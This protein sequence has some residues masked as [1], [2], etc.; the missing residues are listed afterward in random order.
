MR[1]VMM[2]TSA[3]A[4]PTLAALTTFADVVAVVTQPDRPSGRGRHLSASPVKQFAEQH[5]MTVYQPE[6]VREEGFVQQ[7]RDLGPLDAIVVAAFGQIIPNSILEM[8][9]LGC[10]NVHASLLPKYRGAAPIQHAIMNGETQSGVTT[11]LMDPGLDT[12]PILLQ[13]ATEIPPDETG[14][15]LEARLA[16]IGAGLLFHTLTALDRHHIEPT[17]QDSSQATLAPSLRRENGIVDWNLSARR[18]VNMVR[19]F[20]PRPGAFTSIDGLAIRIWQADVNITEAAEPASVLSVTTDGI[21]VAT[22]EGSVLIL[23]LQP[24]NRKRMSA[25]DFARGV[26]LTPGASFDRASR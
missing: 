9:R 21:A 22:G 3:F 19:A 2:G 6:R 13:E 20:T 25:A 4:V 24:E 18:I 26:R 10:V 8:P 11:M 5:G 17:P 16:D 7:V 12:G 23:E 15:E 1:I 14:G